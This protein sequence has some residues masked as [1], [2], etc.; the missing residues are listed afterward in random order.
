MGVANRQKIHDAFKRNL[1]AKID[2]QLAKRGESR[3]EW[4]EKRQIACDAKSTVLAALA[5][6]KSC[7]VMFGKL[8]AF[9]SREKEFEQRLERFNVVYESQTR[10]LAAYYFAEFSKAFQEANDHSKIEG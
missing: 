2:I 4:D 8:Y 1:D 9:G 7:R 3:D 10:S 5:M 6:C